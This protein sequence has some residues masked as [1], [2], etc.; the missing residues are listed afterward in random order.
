VP[1]PA[2]RPQ[3]P[4]SRLA[5]RRRF[6]PET[7]FGGFTELDGAIRFYARVRELLPADGVALDIGCGRG[8]QDD[9]PVAVRRDLRI[10]RGHCAKVIGIDV[11][12]A[13]AENRFVDEFRP[14]GADMRWPVDDGSVDLGLADFVVEHVPDPDA[15]FSEAARVIKPGGHLCI[16]TINR[17]SYLGLAS[18]LVPSGLHKA[19]LRHAQPERKAEDVF[20]TLYRANTRRVLASALERAG[21]DATVYTSEDEPSYLT[22]SP[23]AY[24]AGLLHRRLAP[25]SILVG[26]V[27]W[28][29][30]RP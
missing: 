10:L 25:R 26:L 1:T 29:R 7:E 28:G 8:T 16:R 9:D 2:E 30:R 14:V 11:D 24:R 15:F 4:G 19:T 12:E 18:R 21:F 5:L 23:L 13:G 17:R 6:H 22:F 3:P 27:A 20:P